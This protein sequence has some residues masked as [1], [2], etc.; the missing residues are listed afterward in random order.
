MSKRW[1]TLKLSLG[2]SVIFLSLLMI[3]CQSEPIQQT[4]EIDAD[5]SRIKSYLGIMSDDLLEGRDTST[6]INP[7]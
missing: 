6:A 1:I 5:A 2:L 3:A 4:P 7:L